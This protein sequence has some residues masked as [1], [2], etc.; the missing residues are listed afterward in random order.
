LHLP[1]IGTG[2]GPFETK[3][4]RPAPERGFWNRFDATARCRA[5][6]ERDEVS[7]RTCPAVNRIPDR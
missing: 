6:E 4:E 5:V 3:A 1:D 2:I 7:D